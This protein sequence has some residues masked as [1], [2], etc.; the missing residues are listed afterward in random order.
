MVISFDY[1]YFQPKTLLFR[2]QIP[3]QVKSKYSLKWS[4]YFRYLKVSMTETMPI[5]NQ[6]ITIATQRVLFLLDCTLLPTEDI[7]LNTRVFQWPKVRTYELRDCYRD[8]VISC[9]HK[10]CFIKTDCMYCIKC[11][12]VYETDFII[13][14]QAVDASITTLLYES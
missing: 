7:Q 1:N 6:K 11:V 13:E 3:C 5:L 4:L 2:T 14:S 8:F 10:V 12:R 9:K